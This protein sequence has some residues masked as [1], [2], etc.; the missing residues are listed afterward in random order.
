MKPFYKIF[1]LVTVF[2]L[3]AARPAEACTPIVEL[4]L[5]F[6]G[7]NIMF[8]FIV[9]PLKCLFFPYFEKRLPRG[10]LI[11]L[12]LAGNF[13]STAMGFIMFIPFTTPLMFPAFLP[14]FFL[15]AYFPARRLVS[16]FKWKFIRPFFLAVIITL[17]IIIT[18]ILFLVAKEFISGGYTGTYWIFKFLYI[19]TGLSISTLLTIVWEETIIARLARK[20][21]GETYFLGS[22]SKAN[23]ASLFLIALFF[24]ALTIPERLSTG[25]FLLIR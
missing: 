20:S 13:F 25:G 14:V 8:F 24:A 15:M 12:M 10:K 16:R 23:L 4:A 11:V 2:G 22:V 18:V 9:I 5:I 21:L 1:I 3:L 7:Y 6:G 17:A 19:I